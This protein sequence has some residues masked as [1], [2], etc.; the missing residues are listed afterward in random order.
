ME[1]IL[2]L[3]QVMQVTGLKCSTIYL[4]SKQG[5]FPR[6]VKLGPKAVGWVA[7]EVQDWIEARKQASRR[8]TK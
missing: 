3:E 2:R 6:Q 7:S 4:Y 5:K 1:K 8:G